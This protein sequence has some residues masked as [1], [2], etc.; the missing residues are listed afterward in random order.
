MVDIVILGGGPAGLSAAVAARN[1]GKSVLL[2]SR[3]AE[4]NP[5]WKAPRVDNYLGLPGKSG[6]ELLTI[7]TTQAVAMGAELRQE[8]VQAM[9]PMGD[10]WV[11]TVGDD[12]VEVRRVILTPGVVRDARVPG[13][14]E[15]LGRGVSYCAT[16]DGMLYRGKQVVVVGRSKDA[17]REANWLREI[18]CQ[19]TYVSA[20]RPEGL[21]PDIAAV[22]ARRLEIRGGEVVTELRADGASIP[23]E[24]VFLL[25]EAVAPTDLLPGLDTEEGYL[26]V[27]RLMAT[28]LPGVYAAG[29]CTGKPLQL[30]KA[31]GEGLIAGEAA[32]DSIAEA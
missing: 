8:K 6:A 12:M 15:F 28:N 18:G 2:F 9:L 26:K 30:A 29:D 27:D 10:H 11:L 17:P 25:R 3:P 32:A 20:Q 23:C 21:R 16:C 31:V 22:T 24:G 7:F 4:E 19:V 13:E 5:L 1:K 14:S